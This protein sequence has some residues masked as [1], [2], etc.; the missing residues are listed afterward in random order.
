MGGLSDRLVDIAYT[1]D[2]KIQYDNFGKLCGVIDFGFDV[3]E[4]TILISFV[5]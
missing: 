3:Y 5:A 4:F 1:R 2:H